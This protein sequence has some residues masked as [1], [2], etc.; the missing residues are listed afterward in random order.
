[1]ISELTWNVS[2]GGALLRPKTKDAQQYCIING[3]YFK[4][5]NVFFVEGYGEFEMSN[6]PVPPDVEIVKSRVEAPSLGGLSKSAKE[7]L[8]RYWGLTK[9]L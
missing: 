2:F 9:F 3:T 7:E 8:C 1:M 5:A 4:W 6:E